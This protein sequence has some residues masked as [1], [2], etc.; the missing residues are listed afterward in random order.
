[1]I[2][3]TFPLFV[4]LVLVSFEQKVARL[5]HF[6]FFK[7]NSALVTGYYENTMAETVGRVSILMNSFFP[8]VVLNI[9]LNS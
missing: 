4:F 2:Y 9:N 7:H 1:M 5:L 8:A 6:Q 3:Y